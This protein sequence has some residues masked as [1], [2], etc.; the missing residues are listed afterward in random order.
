MVLDQI[1]E[2]LASI[3][4]EKCDNINYYYGMVWFQSTII[5]SVILFVIIY[6][7]NY[8]ICITTDICIIKFNVFKYILF[9]WIICMTIWLYKLNNILI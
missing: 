3:W 9:L 4:R 7:I 5:I 6:A 8:W 1:E 2:E